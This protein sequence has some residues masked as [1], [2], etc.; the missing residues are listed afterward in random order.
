MLAASSTEQARDAR[1][2]AATKQLVDELADIERAE[3]QR[4]QNR[5]VVDNRLAR[6]LQQA[7]DLRPT[8]NRAGHPRGNDAR[9]D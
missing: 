7:L 1:T 3:L 4:L 5:G 2:H 9:P 8:R 6:K